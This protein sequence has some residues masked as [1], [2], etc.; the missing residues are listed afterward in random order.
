MSIVADLAW[1]W[2]LRLVLIL[3]ISVGLGMPL[4][5]VFAVQRALDLG[6]IRATRT[7]VKQ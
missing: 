7:G 3:V 2:A 6:P 1:R 5:F 4:G